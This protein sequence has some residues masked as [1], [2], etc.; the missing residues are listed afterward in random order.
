MTKNP[1][2]RET[3]LL[4]AAKELAETMYRWNEINQM[5]LVIENRYTES[6]YYHVTMALEKILLLLGLTPDEK[7]GFYEMVTTGMP[8]EEARQRLLDYR[9]A[10]D[11]EDDEC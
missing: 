3:H 9:P 1:D 11:T 6:P 5:E 4:A 2:P 7:M 10:P 8:P